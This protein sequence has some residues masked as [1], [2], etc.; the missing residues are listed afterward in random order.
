M[1]RIKKYYGKVTAASLSMLMATSLIAQKPVPPVQREAGKLTYTIR[2]NGDR[3]PDYSYAGYEL[4]EKKI[5]LV[6]N[7]IFVQS[8]EGDATEL[9]QSAID[10]VSSLPSDASGFRGA[11]LLDH[12]TFEVAGQLW[13]RTGGVVLRGMGFGPGGTTL[14][15][16]G[17]ARETVINIKGAD[18]AVTG[19][20]LEITDEYVPV[21]AQSLTVASTEGLQVGSRIMVYRVGGESWIAQLG[22]GGDKVGNLDFYFDRTVTGIQR[23]TISLDVPLTNS[24]ARE[25]SGGVVIPYT[26]PGVI[27]QVGVEFLNIVSRY[28]PSNPKDEEHAWYGIHMQ[29]VENAWV[30]QIEFKHLAGSAVV[31]ENRTSKITVRDC[32]SLKPISE[33]GGGRRYTF[34]TMGQM[35]LFQHC[36]S[37]YGYHDFIAGNTTPG[38][39]AFV[40]CRAEEPH[41]FSGALG[42]W[43]NGLL[44]DDVYINGNML[45]FQNRENDGN[46]AGWTGANSLMWNCQASVLLNYQPP[47]AANWAFGCWAQVKGTPSF[48]PNN[49]ISPRSFFYA[50]LSQRLGR[51]VLAQGRIMP[52]EGNA[53]TSPS[54]EVARQQSLDALE[55]EVTLIDWIRRQKTPES[56][57]IVAGVPD[58][59]ILPKM[60]PVDSGSPFSLKNGW[61]VRENKVVTGGTQSVRW[62]SGSDKPLGIA[63]ATA[64]L[65][66]YV[67]GRRG[68]GLTDEL[69]LMTDRMVERNIAVTEFKYALWYDRRRDDHQRFRQMDGE[70]WTPFYELPFARSGEGRAWDG[71]SKYDLTRFNNWYF[72]RLAE[73]ARLGREKGLV[74]FNEH[75]QQHNILEAGAHYVDFPWRPANNVNGT[76][77]VEPVNFAGEKRIFYDLQ[78]YDVS[79]P[80]YAALHRGYIR[81]QLENFPEGTGVI[82]ATSAEYTGPFHFVEFWLKTIGEWEKETGKKALVALSA[83]KDVQDRVLAEPAL[84]SIVDIIDIRYWSEGEDGLN[85]PEGGIHLAPRQHV[86]INSGGKSGKIT[87]KTVNRAVRRYREENPGKAVTYYSTN[88]QQNAWGAFMGGASLAALPRI[89]VPGF[90]EADAA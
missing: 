22:T 35:T 52:I 75:Y 17:N 27:S 60:K 1:K 39:N 64:H 16:T 18:D 89:Q 41:F 15:A 57:L 54:I 53:S 34:Y 37:E 49:H 78:F 11:V 83:P 84:A 25:E 43:V 46:Q 45:G 20:P 82:H 55:P 87:E 2:E 73:Y 59:S 51:S 50:Q 86:R 72:K 3:V 62:W 90:L 5:P 58:Q 30:R 65:T 4:S 19:Q 47:G 6:P 28:D 31:L 8:V 63:Q 67:P 71:L 36:Y 24:I 88:Y 26:W 85:A 42:N 9:I 66:R 79:D 10:Y 23:N 77:M 69:D 7:K 68:H 40:Q 48:D 12:G 21:N 32:I 81:H 56:A 29:S 33:I 70:V 61:L 44:L 14:Y 38:P 80:D 74:L 13:I 76:P